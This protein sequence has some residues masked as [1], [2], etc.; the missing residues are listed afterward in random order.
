MAVVTTMVFTMHCCKRL[1]NKAWLGVVWVLVALIVAPAW[2]DELPSPKPRLQ[3]EQSGEAILL[4]AQFELTLPA[5]V[6]EALSK[7][8]PIYF[9]MS[10]R[11]L[12]ER[13]YWT[14]EVLST[15]RRQI[16]LAYH[17]LTQR[18]RTSVVTAE[19]IEGN[20]GLSFE[21]SHES[22][23]AA[24]SAVRRVSGWPVAEGVKL[25]KDQRYRV[26]F[27]FELDV[28]RLPRP[29]QIGTLGQSD[30]KVSVQIA[31]PVAHN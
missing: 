11:L 7:G 31:E 26:D 6:E 1:C 24:M 2:A 4:S 5:V 9:A 23:A 28:N 13:W 19:Q 17:P 27:L 16:R 25:L 3:L 10:A 22:L 18:W 30:W 20:Q 15:T 29:L 8:I 21:Q 14:N 12:R